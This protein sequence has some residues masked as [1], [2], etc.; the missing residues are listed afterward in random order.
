MS[1]QSGALSLS[2]SVDSFEEAARESEIKKRKVVEDSTEEG[3]ALR[4]RDHLFLIFRNL[5]VGDLLAVGAVCRFWRGASLKPEL[6]TLDL[7]RRSFPSVSVLGEAQIRRDLILLK[8]IPALKQMAKLKI[9]GNAGVSIVA[10]NNTSINQLILSCKFNTVERAVKSRI[11]D[12]EVTGIWVI[13]NSGLE[14]TGDMTYEEQEQHVRKLGFEMHELVP[15]TALSVLTKDKKLFGDDPL[16]YVRCSNSIQAL[17]GKMNVIFG[18]K[19]EKGANILTFE[20]SERIAH[21]YAGAM[22][23][24]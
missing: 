1:L 2:T 22:K 13:T 24:V 7:M 18:G 16:I 21:H 23:K 14:G 17:Q 12:Q 10:V 4:S 19:S 15:T 6:W 11:G 8:L 20:C 3:E 9:L 5:N